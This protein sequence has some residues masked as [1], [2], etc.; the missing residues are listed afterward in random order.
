MTGSVAMLERSVYNWTFGVR[1][2]LD[3]MYI[4]PCLPKQYE[5]SEI[6]LAYMNSKVTVKYNGYGNK[7]T[8]ATVND[9]A[10]APQNGVLKLDKDM[11]SSD[12]VIVLNM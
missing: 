7:I 2:T 6:T 5:N 10:V 12:T 4:K 1:Y 11:L 9:K 3:G 8:T